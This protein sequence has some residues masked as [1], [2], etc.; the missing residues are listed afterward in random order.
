MTNI[1]S[2]I[3]T[4]IASLVQQALDLGPRGDLRKSLESALD[5]AN[6]T[7]PT[8]LAELRYRQLKAGKRLTDPK[9][10]G[11]I[12]VASSRGAKRWL[13]RS[14]KDGKQQQVTLGTYP[15][16]SLADARTEWSRVASEGITPTVADEL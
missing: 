2:S 1:K 4:E 11:F 14:Q 13:Y 9:R 12:M 10:A 8:D 5:E 3:R 15:A 6:G 16:M 7:A